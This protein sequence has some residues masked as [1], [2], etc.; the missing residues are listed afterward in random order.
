[1]SIAPAGMGS[2]AEAFLKRIAPGF[3]AQPM[4]CG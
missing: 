4:A 1:L 3:S 2:A